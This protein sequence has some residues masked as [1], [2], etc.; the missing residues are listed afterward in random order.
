MADSQTTKP[1]PSLHRLLLRRLAAMTTLACVFFSALAYWRDMS[2]FDDAILQSAL[3]GAGKFRHAILSELDKRDHIDSHR[4]QKVLDDLAANAP[5]KDSPL[6][7]VVAVRISGRDNSTIAKRPPAGSLQASEIEAYLDNHEEPE[8]ATRV[9]EHLVRI[10][11]RPH[12]H[13]GIPLADSS[14][15]D[16]AQAQ[17]L[18]AVSDFALR[19]IAMGSVRTIGMVVLVVLS[20]T[21]LLY[22]VILRL[23]RHVAEMAAHT[24]QANLEILSVLG[25]AIAKRDS[26]TDQH[27]DRVTIYAVRLAE[28]MAWDGTAIRGLIKGALLHDVGKIGIRDAVLLKPGRL[29]PEEFA[30]MRQHVRHGHEIVVR[31]HWLEDA[32]PVITG[33]HEKFDGSGY[34]KGLSG[35][36]IPAPARL[37]AI[38]DVF[39]ALTSQRPYKQ[40]LPLQESLA[41]LEQG[42]GSHFD[43]DMLDVFTRIVPELHA[44]IAASRDEALKDELQAMFK[45][46][47]SADVADMMRQA[48]AFAARGRLRNLRNLPHGPHDEERREA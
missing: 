46:Y 22:P 37:F 9:F 34:D 42:R 27:N 44:R 47:F 20:T 31:A 7:K 18:Y 43:P 15:T 8:N 32:L 16:V 35:Q 40:P 11:D 4:V 10:G 36:A 3:L 5:D 24:Q 48:E 21:L 38:V 41:L 14:G 17:A 26:D 6:G 12:L 25:G 1:Q 30:D 29:T 28:A 2:N 45:R 13:L 23:L 33:H 19:E 39:D